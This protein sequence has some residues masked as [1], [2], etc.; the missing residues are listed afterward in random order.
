MLC[1]LEAMFFCHALNQEIF[2][3]VGNNEWNGDLFF[4][5]CLKRE[6]VHLETYISGPVISDYKVIL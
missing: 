3:V 1:L 4:L 5:D 2:K 6:T